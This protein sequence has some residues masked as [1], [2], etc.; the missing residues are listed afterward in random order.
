MHNECVGGSRAVVLIAV[1]PFRLDVVRNSGKTT[2]KVERRTS[3]ARK[4]EHSEHPLLLLGDR[5]W[6]RTALDAST[7]EVDRECLSLHF[8]RQ[9]TVRQL[10]GERL[11]RMRSGNED[12]A[13]F[14]LR[15]K[16]RAR[17]STR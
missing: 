3:W 1:A 8:L 5:R 11:T 4:G 6:V 10:A 15:M 17:S 16:Q 13:N 12:A 7:P 14:G 9:P 2:L